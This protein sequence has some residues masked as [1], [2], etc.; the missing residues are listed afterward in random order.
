[1]NKKIK[2]AFATITCIASYNLN[3]QILNYLAQI[4]AT[5]AAIPYVFEGRVESVEIYAGDDSGN[6]LPWSAAQ[7]NGDIGYF[8]DQAGN[9][10]KGY[11]L[12]KIKVCKVYKGRIIPDEGVI[13]LTKSHT[14][15]NVYLQKIGIGADADTVLRYIEVMPSHDEGEYS[16]ILP[17]INYP[18][19][20]Y[21]CGRIDPILPSAYMGKE[22]NS[23]FQSILEMPFNQPIYIPQPDG[24][25]LYKTAYCSLVPYA[26]DDQSQLQI[27]LNQIQTINP[28][29]TDFC[30]AGDSKE[31]V[32]IKETSSDIF[33][34][35]VYP[36]PSQSGE[37]V[38]VK[39]NSEEV[40]NVFMDILDITGKK[41]LHFDLGKRKAMNYDLKA[42]LQ[43]GIYF[44][45]VQFGENKKTI[46]I[47]KN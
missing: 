46:K 9:E 17:Q 45:Q 5:I 32:V 28:N 7:W 22:Y 21:F 20:I 25:L 6:K 3:A 8:Y 10:A 30:A 38:K 19:K 2:L 1:M 16:L 18:K 13:V 35:S 31:T 40:K 44:L 33:T 24:S 15:N 29:P 41:I 39:F 12:A 4:N 37:S 42:D 14:I 11:S 34:V 27:F 47:N 36:N 26:F 23:N 43:P